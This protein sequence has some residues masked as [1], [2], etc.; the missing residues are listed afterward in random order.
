MGGV[1]KYIKLNSGYSI[2]TV[3]LGTWKLSRTETASI[4]YTALK[5]GYRHFDTAILYGNEREVGDGIAKW[6]K[7]DP[8][9]NKREDVFYTS[10]L[11][12]FNSYEQA[13]HEIKKAL[14]AVEDKLGYIDLLL[15]HSPTPGPVGRLEA[16]GA[17]QETVDAGKVRSI[18]VSSWGEHHLKQLFAWKGY[19]IK[20]AVNQIEISPWI[21]RQNLA[22]YCKSEGIAIEAYSP[23]AHGGRLSDPTVQKI[24]KKYNVSSAQVLIRWSLQKG[25]IPLPKSSNVE[26]LTSNLDVYDFELSAQEVE[27]ISHPESHDPT[28]WDVTDIE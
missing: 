18:G 7:E 11:W 10:K 8:A 25:Y 6:L 4:V 5:K 15:L 12:T 20:P 9:N 16:W 13:K 27:E 23:L 28:D 14:D 1:E 21:M 22:D 2:P 3:A 17:L 24:A 19:K 26:R